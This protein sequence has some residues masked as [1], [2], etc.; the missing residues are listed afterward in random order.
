[1]LANSGPAPARS[2]DEADGHRR[3]R[4]LS[5]LFTGLKPLLNSLSSDTFRQADMETRET[6]SARDIAALARSLTASDPSRLDAELEKLVRSAGGDHPAPLVKAVISGLADGRIQ[7]SRTAALPA[8]RLEELRQRLGK[9][10]VLRR[11]D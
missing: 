1:M 11:G 9:K 2:L 7:W 5:R 10:A 3:D 6:V 4:M 8:G